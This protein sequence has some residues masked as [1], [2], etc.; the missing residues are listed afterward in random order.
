MKR[1]PFLRLLLAILL[2]VLIFVAAINVTGC[3]DIWW[4]CMQSQKFWTVVTGLSA[5]VAIV[6]K[7]I[8]NSES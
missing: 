3:G 8:W 6:L 2:V 1:K 5:I 7:I 4:I